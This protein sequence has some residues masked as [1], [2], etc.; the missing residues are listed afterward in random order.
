[1][2]SNEKI[3]LIPNEIKYDYQKFMNDKVNFLRKK[4]IQFGVDIVEVD[5]DDNYELILNAFL[6][7]RKKMK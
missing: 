3:K 5:I 2:E 7:K 4:S 6:R 1:M